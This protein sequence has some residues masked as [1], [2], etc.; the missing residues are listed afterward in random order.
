MA[1]MEE[2]GIMEARQL[3]PGG[4]PVDVVEELASKIAD[5]SVAHAFRLFM[6]SSAL[7]EIAAE[8][9]TTGPDKLIVDRLATSRPEA[10]LQLRAGTYAIEVSAEEAHSGLCQSYACN[11]PAEI[12]IAVEFVAPS[13]TQTAQE[14]REQSLGARLGQPIIRSPDDEPAI[15]SGSRKSTL[16]QMAA[17]GAG[18]LVRIVSTTTAAQGHTVYITELVQADRS[19][20]LSVVASATKR[21]T[22]WDIL[23]REIQAATRALAAGRDL[24]LIDFPSKSTRKSSRVIEQRAV[25]L[26]RWLNAV[27]AVDATRSTAASRGLILDI[28]LR[29][30]KCPMATQIGSGSPARSISSMDSR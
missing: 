26:S 25:E 7:S 12:V 16:L 2:L 14:V 30:F 1:A 3:A 10:I 5:H 9:P 17:D 23:R 8:D 15:I 22:E 24:A 13:E 18:F 4:L 20:D 19:G 28:V 21:Y 29:W 6:S 27:L 11:R